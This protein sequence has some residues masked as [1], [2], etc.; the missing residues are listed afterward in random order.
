M[1]F[2]IILILPF[3]VFADDQKEQKVEYVYLIFPEKC[4]NEIFNKSEYSID[5]MADVHNL[6]TRLLQGL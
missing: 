2:L 1:N 5:C 3:I 6:I 4:Y